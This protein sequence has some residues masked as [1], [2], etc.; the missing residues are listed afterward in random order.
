CLRSKTPKSYP[1]TIVAGSLPKPQHA[2]QVGRRLKRR[3][4][5]KRKRSANARRPRKSRK[6]VLEKNQRKKPQRRRPQLLEHPMTEK[7]A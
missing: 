1:K 2:G 3:S 6:L 5:V 4:R 7:W